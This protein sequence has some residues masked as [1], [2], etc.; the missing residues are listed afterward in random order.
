MLPGTAYLR[1]DGARGAYRMRRGSLQRVVKE[2]VVCAGVGGY[3][4]GAGSCIESV[5]YRVAGECVHGDAFIHI[6]RR[7]EQG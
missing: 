6:S 3:S 2:C 5:I 7:V 4:F 1:A